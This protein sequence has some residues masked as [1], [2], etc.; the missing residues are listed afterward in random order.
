V[1][2]RR[3]FNWFM[4]RTLYG[5]FVA[6]EDLESVHPVISRYRASGIRS[7]LDYAV[8]EDI[9][10]QEVEMET[11]RKHP[12]PV[13]PTNNPEAH[14]QSKTSRTTGETTFR[15]SAR[16]YFYEGEEKCDQNKGYFI[17]CIDTAADATGGDDA[18]AAIKLTGLGRPEL[19]LRWSEVVVDM[20]KIFLRL[21]DSNSML[22][23]LITPES[24]HRGM[25]EMGVGGS[26]E[27][28]GG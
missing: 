11:R 2:G 8:E 19:L 13:S 22:E 5:Q 17:S 14:S 18:F 1:L 24:F 3:L 23:A 16:T 12:E 21:A 20:Q 6:G 28:E 9:G 4:K 15:A 27:G 7:I 25:A 26:E 10:N